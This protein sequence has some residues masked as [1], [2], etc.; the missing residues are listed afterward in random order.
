MLISQDARQSDLFGIAKGEAIAAL[1]TTKLT[2]KIDDKAIREKIIYGPFKLRPANVRALSYSER[3]DRIV[4][5]KP[6]GL[7]SSIRNSPKA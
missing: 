7:T 6:E 5:H 4:T 3:D 2:P 1:S